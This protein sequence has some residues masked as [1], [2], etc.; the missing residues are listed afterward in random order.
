MATMYEIRSG[1][2]SVSHQCAG[3]AREALVEYLRSLGCSRDEIA[4]MGVDSVAWR[5]AMYSA[6]PAVADELLARRAA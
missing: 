6:V 2:R 1:R 4:T 3:T 5:G